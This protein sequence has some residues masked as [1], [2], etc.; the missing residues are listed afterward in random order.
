MVAS[1]AP[2]AGGTT[3]SINGAGFG[4][5]NA[6]DTVQ[7]CTAAQ[8]CTPGVSPSVV[9]DALITVTTPDMSSNQVNGQP[10][11]LW[12]NVIVTNANGQQSSYSTGSKFLF[13]CQNY[14]DLST[15]QYTAG[16]CF[17][18]PAPGNTQYQTNQVTT[19]DGAQLVSSGTDQADVNTG[20][21]SYTAQS[22]SSLQ[23]QLPGSQLATLLTGVTNIDLTQGSVTLTAAAGANLAGFPVSGSVTL[24]AVTQQTMKIVATV[25]LPTILGGASGTIT[26]MTTQGTGVTSMN[27]VVAAGQPE[28]VAQVFSLT[29]L[30][31]SWTASSNTWTVN[32]TGTATSNPFT[33]NGNLTYGNAG[34][35]SGN[36]SLTGGVVL[37][38]GVITFNSVM[39]TYATAT[40]WSASASVTQ[41]TGSLTFAIAVDANGNI[42][43]GSITSNGAITL[44]GAI[45]LQSFSM[46]WAGGTW[47]A[48]ATGGAGG[49]NSISVSTVPGAG[50]IQSFQ[51]ALANITLG[52]VLQVNSLNIGYKA[53]NND[54][55]GQINVTL[56]GSHI[57]IAGSID[58][59]NGAFNS[60]SLNFTGLHI[61]LGQTGVF[62][63]GG[64]AA[65]GLTPTLSLTGGVNLEFGPEIAGLAAF[66]AA[67]QL[68]Y[69]FASSGNG[70]NTPWS[71][72]MTGSVA[73]GGVPG[74]GKAI[75]LGNGQISI[76]Q[77]GT[78]TICVAAGAA[79]SGGCTS[80]TF[81]PLKYGSI[82]LHEM[83]SG[84][85][86]GA[87]S[88]Q[89]ADL[90]GTLQAKGTWVT[91]A[92]VFEINS[93]GIA[94]CAAGHGFTWLWGNS[95][96]S[97]GCPT[98]GFTA[99]N[100]TAASSGS[101]DPTTGLNVDQGGSASVSASG[102][103]PGESVT[104]TLASSGVSAG[105]AIADGSGD[106]TVAVTIPG[107]EALG[108]DTLVLT[109]AT[110]GAA[111]ALPLL[112][113][114]AAASSPTTVEV[115]GPTSVAAGGD[116]SGAGLADG[117]PA[118]TYSAL[119]RP[120]VD[121]HR[122]ELG[123]DRGH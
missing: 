42:T 116:V 115:F 118:P 107:D 11:A 83:V 29:G 104:A 73:A 86:I 46:T 80:A 43:S 84:Q 77:G 32:A 48:S 99:P 62:I 101:G 57:G 37:G 81:I 95:T 98:S 114:T 23:L 78:A 10:L 113:S 6:A 122:S 9:G 25:K 44:F 110:S 21:G 120:D 1:A 12:T 70:P 61:P 28:N 108:S 121:V 41:A 97:S 75:T 102:F 66:G 40:G 68:N 14:P 16:G 36:L 79:G 85:L 51:L 13:G 69:T 71:A 20:S 119:R 18:P 91:G 59:Q 47:S 7:F 53:T 15:G 38:G 105:S 111:V 117:T 67:V 74:T 64:S 76:S 54:Y 63:V 33:L 5:A 52:S 100:I 94:A 35:T 93:L 60:A 22:A 96:P 109:G 24:S 103:F 82:D 17:I 106:A 3:V 31:L 34:I 8:A 55:S 90:Q 39:F 112:V 123:R 2:W 56:T 30:T 87:V 27:I 19:L 88:P 50:G 58:F 26:V 72:T 65:V 49:Q 4:S 92:A 45:T 89:G